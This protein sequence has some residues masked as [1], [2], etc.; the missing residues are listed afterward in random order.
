MLY[1][2]HCYGRQQPQVHNEVKKYR[3]I[4][5][6]VQGME[7]TYSKRRPHSGQDKRKPDDK[8]TLFRGSD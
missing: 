7:D 3:R 2:Y 5:K 4:P 6:P 8:E 1:S